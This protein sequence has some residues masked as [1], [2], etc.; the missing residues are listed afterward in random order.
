[1]LISFSAHA[2]MDLIKSTYAKAGLSLR[3][4]GFFEA[5]GTGTPIGDPLELSSLGA[6]FGSSKLP[7]DPPLYVSSVK[8]NVGHT[9]GCSAI[10]G[11][12][13]AI[14]CLEKGQIGPNADFESLNPRLRLDEWRL[15]IPPKTISWPAL[16]VRR[17]SVNSFG[18]GGA[19]GHVILDDAHSYLHAHGLQGNDST[20]TSTETESSEHDS[21]ISD[22]SSTQN[23]PAY[24]A[25]QR[26]LFVFSA[27]D[28]AGIARVAQKYLQFL[29]KRIQQ[30]ESAEHA[31]RLDEK[32]YAE[33]L[34]YTLASRRSLFDYRTFAVGDS[35]RDLRT[36]MEAGLPN[37]P[38]TST[39]NNLFFVFT[40]QGAQWPA[41]GRELLTEPVFRSSF[42]QSQHILEELGCRWKMARCLEHGDKKIDRPEFSQTI[43]TAVQLAL[44]SL[45]ESWGATPQAVV[46]HSS[47]EIA[48][49]FAAKVISQA[50]AMRIA[51]TRGLLSEK[52]SERMKEVSGSMLAAGISEN[53]A[54][55]YL[56]Q[57]SSGKA[58]VACINSP[59]SVTLSGDTAAIEQLEK[60]LNEN[61]KFARKLKVQTAYHSH[62]MNAISDDYMKALKSVRTLAPPKD[63][64]RMFSSVTGELIESKN[65]DGPY[66]V[67]NMVSPVKFSHAVQSLLQFSVRVRGRRKT[68]EYTAAVEIGPHE[69]LKGPLQQIMVSVNQKLISSVTYTS[70]LS[71]GSN[72]ESTAMAAAG[73]LWA[74][75]V[76]VDLAKVNHQIDERNYKVLEDLPAYPW[77]HRKE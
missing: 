18:Y 45:L 10:A 1:M 28:Q 76:E 5:H 74:R 75:G 48:A 56:G 46:G 11:I 19:N 12:I 51:Y 3:E 2:Q 6:T 7:D 21:G 39:Q 57:L 47:G 30:E 68:I 67:R 70:L 27:A 59:T 23:E 36:Y 65:L 43:C 69:A 63:A 60:A 64:P 8:T 54:S 34:A 37:I 29:Q 62:H 73:T 32:L 14:L 50:D 31:G 17:V 16:G 66:W 38:R 42:D 40:G 24:A 71:R 13:K 52:V 49:A 22:T 55:Q 26:K 33:N 4:T 58:V 72:A 9:E 35:L 15:A 77:N 61:G 41:M 25:S 44:L 20:V 53:E